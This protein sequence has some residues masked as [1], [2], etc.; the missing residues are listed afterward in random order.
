MST[1]VIHN[2]FLSFWFDLAV[3]INSLKK[4]RG[5]NVGGHDQNGILKVYSSAL[6]ICNSS[7]VQYLKKYIEYI[8]M[9]FF[10]LIEQ[11]YTV[12]FTTNSFCQ[13][14]AFFVSNISRRRSDQ[15]RYRIF[16][17]VLTHIDSYH[18]LFVIKQRCCQSFCKFCLTNTGR[19]KEKE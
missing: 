17:H 6:R 15:T 8:R 10:N 12:W 19:S 3:F 7:I 14:A 1:Q 16:L 5:T 2:L 18:I 13:L 9:C 11:Y 4:I